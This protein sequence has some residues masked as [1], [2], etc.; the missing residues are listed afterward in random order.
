MIAWARLSWPQSVFQSMLTR[1]RYTVAYAYSYRL[2]PPVSDQ[3]K[4]SFVIFDIWALRR[5]GLSVRVR[6]SARMSKITNDCL[7]RSGTGCC[8][9]MAPVGVK[10][11]NSCV[12]SFDSYRIVKILC[13]LFSP[14]NDFRCTF[15]AER[16]GEGTLKPTITDLCSCYTFNNDPNNQLSSHTSGWYSAS[17]WILSL[18]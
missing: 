10:G 18:R 11:I 16:C 1:W 14:A 12:A 5:S 13:Y 2:K 9:R 15:G 4:P 6:Q 3:V 17:S 7:T 8:T